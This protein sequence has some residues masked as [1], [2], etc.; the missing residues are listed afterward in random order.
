MARTRLR[1]MHQDN[2]KRKLE[3]LRQAQGIVSEPLFPSAVVAKQPNDHV[4]LDIEQPAQS[5]E[6]ENDPENFIPPP[7]PP[8]ELNRDVRGLG[9]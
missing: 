8:I 9:L 3:C 6:D 7:L 5:I 1:D 2:L 4:E